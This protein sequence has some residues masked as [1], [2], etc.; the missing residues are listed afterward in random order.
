[1]YLEIYLLQ[2]KTITHDYTNVHALPLGINTVPF[3]RWDV[4]TARYYF[5]VGNGCKMSK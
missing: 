3:S 2:N 5:D 1:M 4:K